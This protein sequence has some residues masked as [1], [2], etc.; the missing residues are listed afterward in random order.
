MNQNKAVQAKDE[1]KSIG[2]SNFGV[3]KFDIIEALR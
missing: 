3:N 1:N 2:N